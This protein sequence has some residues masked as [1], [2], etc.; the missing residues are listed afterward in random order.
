VSDA[1]PSSATSQDRARDTA[2]MIFMTRLSQAF[3]GRV[4]RGGWA[5]P[6]LTLLFLIF[7]GV[8]IGVVVW[9][10]VR[11]TRSQHPVHPGSP[12]DPAME[13]LRLRFARGEIGAD[14]YAARAAQLSGVLVPPGP[15]PPPAPTT[16]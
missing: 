4:H 5:H 14:E 12:P 1:A 6:W 13:T 9:A 2:F 11:G 15:P 7:V 10:L 8:A 16:S 3:Y